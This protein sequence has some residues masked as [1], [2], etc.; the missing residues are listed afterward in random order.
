ML[1][2]AENKY[3]VSI[4]QLRIT[5]VFIVS[6]GI[7]I[8]KQDGKTG[9]KYLFP[10]YFHMKFRFQKTSQSYQISEYSRYPEMIHFDVIQTDNETNKLKSVCDRNFARIHEYLRSYVTKTPKRTQETHQS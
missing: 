8:M 9:S 7:I 10:F 4:Y 5:C 2:I 3:R 1:G 6:D